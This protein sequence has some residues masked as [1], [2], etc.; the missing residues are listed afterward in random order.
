MEAKLED[1]VL[2]GK[3]HASS[4]SVAVADWYLSLWNTQFEIFYELVNSCISVSC[5]QKKKKVG[6]SNM[7]SHFTFE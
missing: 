1:H 4:S 5:M 2:D 7:L 3:D 6:F